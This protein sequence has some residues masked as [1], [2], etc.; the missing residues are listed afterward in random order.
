MTSFRTFKK[1]FR[2]FNFSK[3]LYRRHWRHRAIVYLS[4]TQPHHT[5]CLSSCRGF[6]NFIFYLCLSLFFLSSLTLKGDSRRAGWGEMK[7]ISSS[8]GRQTHSCAGEQRE[9]MAELSLHHLWSS[10]SPV[11]EGLQ[12]RAEF[13][14]QLLKTVRM[15]D[16]R[17][18][19]AFTHLHTPGVTWP[20][21]A[22]GVP[23]SLSEPG[24]EWRA[25]CHGFVVIT[26]FIVSQS[27]SALCKMKRNSTDHELKYYLK[28]VQNYNNNVSVA[29]VH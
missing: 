2:S 11:N 1:G 5:Q 15:S 18:F 3:L 16:G 4:H 21:T 14:S 22:V 25:K 23:A 27:I 9:G 10:L 26:L 6:N 29:C 13:V 7:N 12:V 19:Q 8:W 20:T 17:E 28:C 24:G